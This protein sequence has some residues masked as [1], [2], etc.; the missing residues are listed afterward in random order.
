MNIQTYP[1]RHWFNADSPDP[2][3]IDIRDIAHSLALLNRFAGHTPEPYSV[4][5]H[6]VLVAEMAPEG[7][8]LQALLHDAHEAY[9]VDMP[10]PWKPLLPDYR[11]ME[12]RVAT[13]VRA[14]FGQTAALDPVVDYTDRCMLVTEARA[15]GFTWWDDYPAYKPY[16]EIGAAVTPWNWRDAERIFMK[17]FHYLMGG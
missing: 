12:S 3:T 4:A 13:A 10:S 15:F 5:Q 7:L 16:L 6:S 1:C 9:V 17:R 11:A 8:K 14:K 2:A